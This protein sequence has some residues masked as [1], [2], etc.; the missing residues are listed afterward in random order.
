MYNIYIYYI[1]YI[2][3][4]ILVARAL[5]LRALG[6]HVLQLTCCN[7]C[8]CIFHGQKY[9]IVFLSERHVD[10]FFGESKMHWHIS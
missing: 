10:A 7:L 6:T 5:A 4:I 2:L 1:L 8:Q 9:V 3:Y